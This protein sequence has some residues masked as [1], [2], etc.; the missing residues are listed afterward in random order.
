MLSKVLVHLEH[1]HLALAAKDSLKL[2]IGQ[3]L[4]LVLGVLQIVGLDVVSHF[5]HHLSAGQR[6]RTD[7]SGQ[8]GRGLQR[9]HQGGAR[10]LGCFGL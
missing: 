5:A 2:V 7:H 9:L 3:D 10:L 4:A 1:A 6:G 8:F